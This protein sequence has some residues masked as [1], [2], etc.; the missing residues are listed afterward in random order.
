MNRSTDTRVDLYSLRV[1]LYQMVTG[2]LPFAAGDAME[3]ILECHLAW[4]RHADDVKP[5]AL[6][7]STDLPIKEWAKM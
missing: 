4:R 5:M 3:W 2:E 1:T 7:G 6:A